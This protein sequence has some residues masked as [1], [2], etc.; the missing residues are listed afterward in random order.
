MTKSNCNNKAINAIYNEVTPA[1][2]HRISA[3]P[4]ANAAQDLLKTVYEGTDTVKQTELQNLTTAFETI[5]MK[6]SETFDEFNSNL[7]KIVN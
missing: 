6:E 5:L 1:E 2:F 3:C 7:S 4:N